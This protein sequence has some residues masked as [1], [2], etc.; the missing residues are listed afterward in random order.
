MLALTL[1]T[2]IAA[3][4]CG[5]SDV[6]SSPK[7]ETVV[8]T[9]QGPSVLTQGER[10]PFTVAV[11]VNGTPLPNPRLQITSSSPTVVAVTAGR[12]SL[13]ALSQG[14]DT[15]TVRLQSSILS[16]SAPTIIQPL[17]VQP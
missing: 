10:V 5:L 16:D 6:F 11:T 12:D 13:V 8:L 3:T 9:Y 7:L 2:G 1:L 17:R 14:K 4:A 15:L